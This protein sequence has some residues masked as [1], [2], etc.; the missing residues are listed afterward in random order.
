MN[1]QKVELRYWL[2]HGNEENKNKSVESKAF[3]ATY[4]IKSAD[5]REKL[6]FKSFVAF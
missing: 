4:G 1:R 2:E 6:L 5:L 3:V